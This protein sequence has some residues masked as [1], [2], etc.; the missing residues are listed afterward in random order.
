MPIKYAMRENV[1]Q[2]MRTKLTS[3][4]VLGPKEKLS[5]GLPGLLP[6]VK[7]P[8]GTRIGARP[9]GWP[10]LPS[11]RPGGSAGAGE[12]AKSAQGKQGVTEQIARWHETAAHSGVQA[13]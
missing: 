12:S 6:V 7:E 1:A 11:L 13:S 10:T 8:R 5:T 3:S 2:E 9:S 4:S